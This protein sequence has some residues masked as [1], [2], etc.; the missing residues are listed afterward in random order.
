M[1]GG[2]LSFWRNSPGANDEES[3]GGG[4]FPIINGTTSNGQAGDCHVVILAEL[5]TMTEP[6][7]GSTTKAKD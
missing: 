5:L 3:Q 4:V 6:R 2:E 7:V 1:S